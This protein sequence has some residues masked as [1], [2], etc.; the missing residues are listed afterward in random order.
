MSDRESEP[1][2][3]E[4]VRGAAEIIIRPSRATDAPQ[5]A[6][7]HADSWRRHYRGAYSDLYLDG[8]VDDDRLAV[9]TQRLAHD[10]AERFTLVAERRDSLVGFVHVV[11]R[12]HGIAL[13]GEPIFQ[14]GA[15]SGHSANEP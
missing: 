15:G 13:F 12:T 2:G 4:S 3:S 14:Y 6:R 5:V 11:D 10:T 8:D 1:E 7:L 9:W